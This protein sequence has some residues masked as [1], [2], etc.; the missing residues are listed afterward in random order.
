VHPDEWINDIQMYFKFDCSEA[1]SLV[2]VSINLPTGIDSFEKLRVET[3]KFISNFRKLCYNAEINDIEEQKIYLYS[4]LPDRYLLDGYKKMENISSISELIKEFEEIIKYNHD[5]IRNGS[6]VAL[7]HVVTGKYLSSIKNLNYNTGS[8]SQLVF[9]NNLL[10][11]NALWKIT[12]TE[13]EEQ[14]LY[15]ETNIYFQH[16]NSKIFLGIYGG[17][18]ESPVT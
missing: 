11:N 4:S 17:Y 6:I 7:K 8:G 5:L 14:A 10:D 13:N 3:S 16:K 15:S 18:F 12:F 9:A 1:L 2:D